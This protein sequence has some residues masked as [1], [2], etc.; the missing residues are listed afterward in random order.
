[1][2]EVMCFLG[3]AIAAGFGF[4]LGLFLHN[5]YQMLNAAGVLREDR[6]DPDSPY[7]FLELSND[8]YARIH[9]KKYVVL[10]VVLENY[11]S[12]PNTSA[13]MESTPHN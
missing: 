13:G 4:I 5:S 10:K 7:L 3:M 2:N 8:G 11:I 12:A 6:S 1:M 9:R